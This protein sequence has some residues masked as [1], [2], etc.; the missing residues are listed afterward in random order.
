MPLRSPKKR[1]LTYKDIVNHL[2][3]V[4]DIN[5][6]MICLWNAAKEGWIPPLSTSREE[7]FRLRKTS[8]P[9]ALKGFIGHQYGFHGIFFNSF[10]GDKIAEKGKLRGPKK[11]SEFGSSLKNVEF[12]SGTY[13]Q[14]S[15]LKNY[16]IYC[17]PPYQ[18]TRCMYYDENHKWRR[19]DNVKFWDW[20]RE[21]SKDNIVF[22]SEY[23]AP[24]DFEM[25]WDYG[26]CVK[27]KKGVNTGSEKIFVCR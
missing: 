11:V 21:M 9:S 27:S 23:T 26:K 4:V 17:D 6:S 16:I 8:T 12:T 5:E 13:D 2:W 7:Y 15:H 24:D 14:F 19:F 20:V 22:V 1:A 3:A 25:L 18:K 10:C